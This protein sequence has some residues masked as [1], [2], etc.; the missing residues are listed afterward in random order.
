MPK[1]TNDSMYDLSAVLDIDAV[2]SIRPGSSILVSGPAMT[3]KEDLLFESLADGAGNGEGAVAVTTGGRAEDVIEDI[4]SRAPGLDS[5][6]LCAIDCR[7]DSDRE[8]YER[9]DGTYVNR[10]AAPADMTGI[11]IGITKCFDRLHDAGVDRGRLGLTNL[12]T[13]VTYTDKQTVFK[14]CH[15]LSSRL[16]SAGFLGL[17]AIDSS[18]H[19]DQTMQVIKQAFDGLIEIRERDGIREARTMGIQPEPSGWV[20][21]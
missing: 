13:M 6:R 14:F 3:G 21:L 16:D 1:S 4:Q 12:S 9:D 2:S 18:A 10:V 17:F 8:E 7:T 19:D 11:G 15:V 20:E 5:Y